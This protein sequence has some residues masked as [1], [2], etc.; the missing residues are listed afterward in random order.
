MMLAEHEYLVCNKS[1]RIDFEKMGS[2][3]KEVVEFKTAFHELHK[4]P[5]KD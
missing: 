4:E 3:I 2:K 1:S 5:I